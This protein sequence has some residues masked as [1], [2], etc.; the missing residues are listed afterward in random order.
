MERTLGHTWEDTNQWI[1]LIFIIGIKQPIPAE[2]YKL[3][4]RKEVESLEINKNNSKKEISF[5]KE[6]VFPVLELYLIRIR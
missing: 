4:Y 1:V 3:A 5:F 2:L 6:E